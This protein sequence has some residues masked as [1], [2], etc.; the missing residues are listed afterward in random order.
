MSA[1]H[2]RGQCGRCAELF[3]LLIPRHFVPSMEQHT[4]VGCGF[5]LAAQD[6]TA[7]I[8]FTAPGPSG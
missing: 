2:W 4:Q 7:G 8:G 1:T 5:T 6:H 3:D